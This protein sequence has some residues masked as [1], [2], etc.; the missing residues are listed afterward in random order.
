MV[1][2]ENHL[3]IGGFLFSPSPAVDS[4][5][6][7]LYP[8]ACIPAANT[9][10]RTGERQMALRVAIGEVTTRQQLRAFVK[11]PWC[12]YKGDPTALWR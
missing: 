7:M 4:L 10:I 3:V 11:S 2:R 1:L 6:R 9:P 12:I 8:I 5:N